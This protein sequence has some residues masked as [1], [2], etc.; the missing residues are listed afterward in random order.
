MIYHGE[1]GNK[2]DEISLSKD[3]FGEESADNIFVDVKAKIIYDSTPGDI[4]NQ[5]ITFAR[6]FDRQIQIYGRTRKA[7]EET[8]RICRDQDV[9]KA[10]LEEEET[11]EIMFTWLD[12]QK[13]KKFEE[14][15]IRQEGRAEGEAK[16][17]SRLGL[18]IN[19]LIKSGRNDDVLRASTDAGYR[20]QLYQELNIQ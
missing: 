1:R 15:E 14:E 9:L 8:L 18:L 3:I 6:V 16:G 12:E 19:M 20:K 7:V 4:I 2:P 5:F 11:A 17:E 13:A 10:Y